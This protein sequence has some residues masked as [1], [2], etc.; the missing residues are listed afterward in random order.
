ME[1]SLSPDQLPKIGRPA[2]KSAGKLKRYQIDLGSTE[3]A[4]DE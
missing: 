4:K 3:R 2:G 1:T